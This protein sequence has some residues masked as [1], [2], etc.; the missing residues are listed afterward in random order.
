MTFA[1]AVV[2]IDHHRAELVHL[3]STDEH[4]AHVTC[5]DPPRKLHRKSGIPGAG[6]APLN[7]EFFDAVARAL[8]DVR[9]VL[10]VGPGIAKVEF[11]AH[12]T[13]RHPALARK[14]AGLEALDH[15]SHAELVGYART[16]FKR[17]DQLEG[18]DLR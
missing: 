18:V 7:R 2:W 17:L 13:Q 10:V 14:V 1:H 8:D 12:L 3:S 5:P 11:A 9:S 16:Y 6:R 4:T 15:P